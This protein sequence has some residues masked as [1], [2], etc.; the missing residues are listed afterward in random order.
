MTRLVVDSSVVIKRSVPKVRLTSLCE[1][2]ADCFTPDLGPHFP[3]EKRAIRL[4]SSCEGKAR[5]AVPRQ[6]EHPVRGPTPTLVG[7][8][9]QSAR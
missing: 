2:R 9:S 4:S 7:A 8:E 6:V 1:I 3:G 5:V